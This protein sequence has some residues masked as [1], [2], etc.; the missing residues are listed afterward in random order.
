MLTNTPDGSNI[1]V[2]DTPYYADRATVPP[3]PI[4]FYSTLS[5]PAWFRAVKFLADNLAAFPRSISKDGVKSDTPHPLQKLLRREPNGYQTPLMLWRTWFFHAAHFWNGY[6]RVE[7]NP[8]TQEPVSLHNW[9]PER[10]IPFRV[11]MNDGRGWSQ[12]Y[13]DIQTREVY[14][15]A[16]VLHLSTVS[17]DG[18]CGMDPTVMHS[19]T[20]QRASTI[21]RFQTRYLQKGTMI[22]GSIEIPTEVDDDLVD[23]ITKRIKEQFAGPDAEKD[24]LILSGG[25]K[26][27]NQGLSPQESQLV[28]Q[29]AQV[30]RQ[31]SQIT[32]VPPQFLYEFSDSKYNNMLTQMGEDVVRY[33]FRP[34]IIQAEGELTSKL[35]N[36]SDQDAGWTVHLNPDALL[37]GDTAA[38][39]ESATGTVAGGLRTQNEGRDLIGLPR[40]N[41]PEADKLKI[42]G[43]STQKTTTAPQR[44]NPSEDDTPPQ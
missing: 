27:N 33:T 29:S 17:Y 39:N 9:M 34:W 15:G 35:L 14:R 3:I 42:L 38:V 43:D 4:N 12:W 19:G 44:T 11:N 10:V 5:V 16:D 40:V 20:F 13:G 32:G 22:K 41:D 18:M 2:I 26:L 37:R 28:E 6:I 8:M 30:T 24:V 25:A 7:R 31:I 23:E 36:A 1:R 21:D